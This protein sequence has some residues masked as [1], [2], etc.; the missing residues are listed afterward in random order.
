[1]FKRTFE[2]FIFLHEPE[3]VIPKKELIAYTDDFVSS[4]ITFVKK[5][6][7]TYDI[8]DCHYY[9][10]GIIGMKI[11][12]DM[13]ISI[14]L[15]MTFHTL[16][17]MKNLVAKTEQEKETTE[18]INAEKL[19]VKKAN[20]IISTG[21]ADAKYLEYLYDCPQDN[22]AIVSPGVNT[23]LFHSIPE[24]SAKQHIGAKQEE[25]IILFV[26]RIE[27]LKGI[28]VLMYAIKILHEKC[29]ECPI[30]LWIVGGD[31]SQIKELWSAELQKLE[32]LRRLLD[33]HEEVKFI[34]RK[35]PEELPYYYNAAEVVVMPS[36]YESFGMSAL[37][38]MACG[39]PVITTNATGVSEFLDSQEEALITSANNPLLLAEQISD[40][41]THKEKRLHI[42]QDVMKKVQALD[43]K[44]IAKKIEKV[45]LSL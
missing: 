2:L 26:G 4:F 28:D 41:L 27:P 6:D 45:Y 19:L 18:R 23:T 30:S 29:E 35:K 14:P 44:Y 7:I 21:E 42:G 40:L 10:S 38:A 5:E 24:E 36:Q 32:E 22:I 43:W 33:I 15:I 37:E 3:I 1:M 11:K 13:H 39:T 16:A 17:L 34:G 8:F 20:H 12:Q 25:K 9:L 31:I